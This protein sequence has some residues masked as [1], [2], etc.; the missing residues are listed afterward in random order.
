MSFSI[1][2]TVNSGVYCQGCQK[3]DA[4][5]VK[6]L[7]VL[8]SARFKGQVILPET[9]VQEIP[10]RQDLRGITTTL[11]SQRVDITALNTP[12]A[13]LATATTG[14]FNM[15]FQDPATGTK[16]VIVMNGGVTAGTP[17]LYSY[18]LVGQSSTNTTRA[19]NA[20]VTNTGDLVFDITPD[21]GT[22]TYR[23]T[24]AENAGTATIQ[25]TAGTI[26]DVN[27]I[28]KKEDDTPYVAPSPP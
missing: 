16:W 11:T 8:E 18:S 19:G 25:Q 23:L 26:T 6:N 28:I 4:I 21:P 1:C 22:L 17:N 2:D 3:F 5:L 12:V 15:Y 9:V 20:N 27:L 10:D 13:I 24:F 7:R 14:V